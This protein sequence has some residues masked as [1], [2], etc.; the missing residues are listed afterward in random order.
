MLKGLAHTQIQIMKALFDAMESKWL[1]LLARA[2]TF[3]F[4]HLF[5]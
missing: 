1:W 2:L 3:F 4:V 5:S